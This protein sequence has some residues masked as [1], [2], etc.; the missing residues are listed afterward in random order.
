[1]CGIVGFY[2]SSF[3]SEEY[4]GSIKRMLSLIKHRGPDEAGY[5]VDQMIAMGTARL[6]IIDLT[7]GTQPLSDRSQRFWICYNGELYNYKELRKEL[8]QKGYVFETSSDTEVVLQSWMHWREECLVRFNGAFAFAIYDTVEET[9]FIARDRYGKRPL[10]YVEQNGELLFASEMKAFLG[11]KG[12]DFSLD[13]AQI[14]SILAI[15]TPLPHQSSFKNIK[16]LPMGEYLLVK[17][18]QVRKKKYEQLTFA[19]PSFTGS[20]SEAIERVREV[21][22]ESVKLQLRSDVEVGIYLSGGLDSSII[23]QLTTQLATKQVHTFSVEFE[24][25]QF[26]E[27]SEQK[28]LAT[29]LK[30]SH[31]AVSIS[32]KDIA[33]NFP[34]AMYH[35]EVPAFRTAFVPMLLLSRLVREHGIKV[36]LS[37]EGS[38]E[39]FLGYDIFKDTLLRKAWNTLSIEEKKDRLAKMYPYL[40]HFNSGDHLMGLYQQFSEEQMPG[41]FSHEMRFQNGRFSNRLLQTQ[42]DPFEAIYTFIANEPEYAGLNPI[43]KT[44]WL[45]FKTLLSGYLLSTQGERMSLAHGIENRCPFL[46]PNVVAFASS[47]NLKFNDGFNEKYLLKRA[48]QHKLPTRIIN[49]PKN[50]YRAPDSSAFVKHRPDYLD[51]LLSDEELKNVEFLNTQFAKTLTKKIFS[52]D[53]SQISTKENQTFIFLLSLTQLHQYFTKRKGLAEYDSQQI[54]NILVRKIDRRKENYEVSR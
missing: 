31:S 9:L 40:S 48:F 44:Q 20:E 43:Q 46:D 15:W 32:Y 18:S 39:A 16:Q 27:S 6:S 28:E 12:F 53:P 34:K 33:E 45:E 54:E 23:T 3:P 7:S 21:L 10:F 37:G 29:H 50:P 14:A 26:D 24:D 22:T 42:V 38:D 25:K 13:P 1:M 51:I 8:Q 49:R 52:S 30:T 4:A 35:A 5:F 41:L 19:T 17:G 36:V 11:Y 2:N 47:I